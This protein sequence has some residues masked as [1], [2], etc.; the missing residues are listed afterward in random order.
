MPAARL[1][2]YRGT[3]PTAWTIRTATWSA[4]DHCAL[5]LDGGTVL[6]AEPGAG[7]SEHESTRTPDAV[8]DLAVPDAAQHI[9]V[10][11]ARTQ[12]GCRYD[13]LAVFGVELHQDWPTKGAWF[14]GSLLAQAFNEA[15]A[16]LLRT[17]H[18]NRV[19]PGELFMSPLLIPV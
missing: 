1:A 12:I 18:V 13:W 17:D 3:G 11:W 14:C 4:Y 2:F 15:H 8:F 6:D 5:L 19:T 7:V 10:G 16:P 9:A